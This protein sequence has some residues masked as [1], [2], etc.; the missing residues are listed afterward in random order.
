MSYLVDESADAFDQLSNAAGRTYP[1]GTEARLSMSQEQAWFLEMLVPDSIAYNF[2]AVLNLHG[3]L[4]IGALERALG[5]LVERHQSLST[6]FVDHGGEPQQRIEDAW[7]VTLPVVDLSKTADSMRDAYA[8]S[9]IRME[10]AQKID[11]GTLPLMRWVLFKHG[12]HDHSLLHIEHHLIHDGW[13]FRLF[14]G[15]L[16]HFYN[17]ERGRPELAALEPAIQFIDYCNWER[18]WLD[19]SAGRVGREFWRRRLTDWSAHGH[20][21][22]PQAQA[23]VTGLDFVGSSVSVPFPAELAS[24]LKH[25][26]SVNKA[27][28]FETMFSLFASVVGTRSGNTRQIV[29]TAVANRDI[30]GIQNTIGMLVNMLPLRVELQGDTRW[31]TL[32]E[33]VKD[34]IRTACAYSHVPFSSMVADLKPARVANL[35]PYIQVGFS[36]HNSMTRQLEF[37]GL[38]V[39]I[40]EGL[41]NGSA[42]F[43]LN[44]IVVFDD[45]ARPE[46]GGRFLLEYS[47][48]STNETGVVSLMDEFFAF[49]NAWLANPETHLKDVVHASSAAEATNERASAEDDDGAFWAAQ[50]ETDAGELVPD[51]LGA[52]VGTELRF[53]RLD[54]A[55]AREPLERLR[56]SCETVGITPAVALFALHATSLAR[57]SGNLDVLAGLVADNDVQALKTLLP[58]AVHVDPTASFAVT[59]RTAEELCR[60]AC[61]HYARSPDVLSAVI[62]AWQ[63]SSGRSAASLLQ[64]AFGVANDVEGISAAGRARIE[65]IVR[66]E[67]DDP[68]L[69]VRYASN[70]FSKH[71]VKLLVEDFSRMLD[72]AAASLDTTLQQAGAALDDNRLRAISEGVR[73]LCQQSTLHEIFESWVAIQ[74]DSVAVRSGVCVWTYAELDAR[75][76]EIA[77]RLLSNGVQPGEAVAVCMPRSP[78]LI[79]A[80]LGILKA[81]GCYLSIDATLP[82]ARRDW[83]LREADVAH[84][85]VDASAPAFADHIAVHRIDGTL[86]ESLAGVRPASRPR[87]D[88]DARCYYMFTSGSTGE[89]KAT[90][91][92]HRAVINLVTN[93]DYLKIGQDDRLLVFAPLAFDASTFEIWGALLNGAQLVV[94][95]G[96]LASL[97]ELGDTLATQQV[98]ILWLTSALF[99]GMVEQH[100]EVLAGARR[101]LTGGDV[102]SADAMRAFFAAGGRQLTIAYGPT[103]GTVFTTAYTLDA[104][105]EVSGRALIGRPIAHRD[106]YVVDVFGNLASEG[107]PGELY[108]GGGV[109][110]EYLKRPELSKER[111]VRLPWLSEHTLF[112]S[113]DVGRWTTDGQVEFLGRR[114]SQIKIRGFRIETG[115]IEQAI[116]G[117]EGVAH[118]AVIVRA[119]GVDKQLVAF[120]APVRGV[121]LSGSAIRDALRQALPDYMVPLNVYSIERL[122]TTPSGKLNK[123]A[124]LELAAQPNPVFVDEPDTEAVSLERLITP[125][126]ADVLKLDKVERHQ[127]FFAIGGH[128]L[129]GMRIMSRLSKTLG[130]RLPLDMLFRY[131]TVASFAEAIKSGGEVSRQLLPDHTSPVRGHSIEPSPTTSSDK[132]NKRALSEPTPQ[133]AAISADVPDI[134]AGSLEGLIAP[135]WADVLKLDKV[136]RHQDFFAIGGHSLAGMRIMSRL[137]K[138]LGRRLPLDMLFRYPTVASFAEA[139]TDGHDVAHL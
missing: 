6:V 90:A 125:I 78:W 68:V 38:D 65:M 46:A 133:L 36:F 89:P 50:I 88:T 91:S 48:S 120:V 80:L 113:G 101:V 49:A 59:F 123:R 109:T 136:E 69:S 31:P 55:L 84:V 17:E 25:Y 11:V 81:G 121:T 51:Q 7:Q 75:A 73:P 53:D 72:A 21:P 54:V 3:E 82:D 23:R 112:R 93:T 26:A 122:P 62:D 76:N 94:Q 127:D 44:V 10:T 40:V 138:T 32:L 16:S 99:Q 103:E 56:Q 74:P 52:L 5:R 61:E 92:D 85:L 129:A 97:E 66:T 15:E 63:Q 114:D 14:L 111:F 47:T 131:P 107:V 18:A 119:Q 27:T 4:D 77:E 102:V 105:E 106:L 30:H 43:D 98:S 71:A 28:L 86:V 95:P 42:K 87:V 67:G 45:E 134:A 41:S 126:W 22:F 118:C 135:V 58:V 137:S 128:S 37:D 35:L 19:S 1:T 12:D 33:R 24:R 34:E 100:P 132:P 117:L 83:Q 57:F 108:V 96:A 79:A 60:R 110:G 139:I 124:L 29:G 130:R 9:L 13:S 64:S 2:Q 70:L 104:A 39:D 115:E 116:R 8:A 20:S